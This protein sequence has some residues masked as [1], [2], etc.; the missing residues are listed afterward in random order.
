MTR[1]GAGTN[2][3]EIVRTFR[4][5][6]I[7]SIQ[8]SIVD[9]TTTGTHVS[10]GYDSSIVTALAAQEAGR[11]GEK[12]RAAFAWAPII[13][14]RYPV[15]GPSDERE[16]IEGLCKRYDVSVIYNEQQ[17]HGFELLL[18]RP[19]EDEGV[20]DVADEFAVLENARACGVKVILSGWGG[21]EAF[22]PH[23]EGLAAWLLKKMELR[24]LIELARRANRGLRPLGRTLLFLWADAIA[25]LLPD[26]IYKRVGPQFE[27]YTGGCYVN[28]DFLAAYPPEPDPDRLPLRPTGDPM[29]YLRRLILH[30]HIQERIRTWAHWGAEYGIEYRYPLLDPQLLEFILSLPPEIVFVN[31]E[32]RALVR[33]AFGDILPPDVG[34]SDPS[35]EERRYR[36][37]IAFWGWL[38]NAIKNEDLY[39]DCPWLDMKRL[40][41]DINRGPGLNPRSNILVFAEIL[42][43]T[44]VWR[45]YLRTEGLQ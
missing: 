33:R 15:R 26:A 29:E 12:L 11:R 31:D 36:E 44:R 30:G 1:H 19:I 13:S 28:P 14:D 41:A 42:V 27:I 22:S 25:P 43:A 4:E 21:D 40:K 5:K 8:N 37:V 3:D 39:R 38:Q 7:V 20:A 32:P 6:T 34:K 16:R 10:G 18:S 24:R 45:M 23:G 35:N 2:L 9:A 17:D